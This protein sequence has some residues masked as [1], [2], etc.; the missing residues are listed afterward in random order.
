MEKIWDYTSLN[1]FLSCR[2][3]YYWR[4]VRHLEPKTVSPALTFGLALHAALDAYYTEGIE[5]ALEIFK[6][7]YKDREGEELRTVANGIK[8]LEAY[9][10]VYKHEPFKVLGKPETG[11]VFPIGDILWGGRMDL[12]VEWNGDL[13][14]VEHKTTARLASN[15]FKQF[16]PNMQ[17][18]SYIAGAQQY[19]GKK[20]HGCVINALEPWKQLKR[21]SAKSK[22]TED[23]FARY[24]ATRSQDDIE[25]FYATVSG[26]VSDIIECESG[27]NN[28]YPN[29]SNCFSYNYDC[30]YKQL[31]VYGDDDRFIK[32][33]YNIS[34]WEPYKQLAEGTD[35]KK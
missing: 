25:D 20:C 13:Y 15:F 26:I 32:R 4:M 31:C 28:F 17:V 8:L 6:A 30:P 12:P 27:L 14:I 22:K 1:I 18:T 19:L 24:V 9:A 3:K 21:P 7:T 16:T 5:K 23:H 29:E 33:D 34:K 10:V 2:R 35:D 11:F